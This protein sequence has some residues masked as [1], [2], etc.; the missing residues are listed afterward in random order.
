MLLTLMVALA[1]VSTFA[2]KV[3][4]DFTNPVE[5]W[6]LP[7]KAN[8]VTEAQTFTNGTYTITLSAPDLAYAGGSEKNG[9]TYLMMGKQGATL[10]LPAFDFAVGTIEVVGNAGASSKTL[11][12]IYVGDNA[13]STET[14]GSTETNKYVIAA[15]SQAAGTIYSLKVNS[16]HNAQIT[17]INIYEAGSEPVVPETPVE[18]AVTVAEALAAASGTTCTVQGVVYA[19]NAR[20]AVIGDATGYINYYKNADPE[21]AIGDKVTITGE[22]D[23]YNGFNQFPAASTVEKTGT[24]TVKYPEPT[25]MSGADLDAWV[26]AP[27]IAYIQYTGV[28]NISGNYYNVNVEGAETAVGSI[29]YPVSSMLE[30][31]TNDSEVVVTGFAMYTS[32]GNKYVNTIVTSVKLKGAAAETTDITNT[33]ETAYTVPQ[34]IALIDAGKGLENK[35]Y[36]KGIIS[37]TYKDML[38]DTSYGNATFF[39]SEDGTQTAPQFEIY[40]GY[41]FGGEKFTDDSVLKLGDEVVFYGTLTKY[42]DTYETNQGAALVLLNGKAEFPQATAIQSVAA[43][44]KGI[45]YNLQGQRVAAPKKGLYIQGGRTILV[46]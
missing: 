15:T 4:L 18:G 20:G 13:V 40:R 2:Q 9:Y 10:T 36:V 22:L 7:L 26:A 1:T 45:I 38:I 16:A 37:N 3:V 27:Q 46:K 24:T 29:A 41:A 11:M 8:G 43:P 23:A 14:T 6:N 19:V 21:L 34:A 32:Y 39:I 44:T 17:K 28:L 30:G 35:V 42:K 31:I 5:N 12:N 33:L 25:V